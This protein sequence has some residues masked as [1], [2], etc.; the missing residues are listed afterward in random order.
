MCHLA[1]QRRRNH[2][3][4]QNGLALFA[5]N[6][7]LLMPFERIKQINIENMQSNSQQMIKKHAHE[8]IKTER[9]PCM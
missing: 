3:V 7:E 8:F 1:A 4:M 2:A 5:F 9:E 6:S